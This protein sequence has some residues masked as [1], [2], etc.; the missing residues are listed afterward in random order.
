MNVT[1]VTWE[2]VRVMVDLE[3]TG[4]TDA[5]A[6]A[7]L[8]DWNDVW[9]DLDANLTSLAQNDIDAYSDLMMEHTIVA[10]LETPERRKTLM[11]SLARITTSLKKEIEQ[12]DADTEM[13]DDLDYELTELTSLMERVGRG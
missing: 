13:S 1:F 9:Q 10:S 5:A 2:F 11:A 6:A 12:S 4:K 7:L 3:E 8:A